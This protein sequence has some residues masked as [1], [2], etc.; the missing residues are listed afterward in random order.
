MMDKKDNENWGSDLFK[1]FGLLL[2]PIVFIITIVKPD[3][4]ADFIKYIIQDKW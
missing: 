1:A 2:L 3:L 4:I